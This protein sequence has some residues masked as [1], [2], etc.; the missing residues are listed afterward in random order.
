MVTVKKKNIILTY[1]NLWRVIVAW[2]C[3][4]LSKHR[5]KLQMDFEAYKRRLMPKGAEEYSELIKFGYMLFE[6]HSFRN[7]MLNRLH[8][9]PMLYILFRILF[10][11]VESLYISMPPE[12]MGGGYSFNMVFRQFCSQNQLEKIVRLTNR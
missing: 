7:V 11:P 3:F 1:A 2:M 4:K 5:E 12:K 8:R 6:E 9:N 10:K